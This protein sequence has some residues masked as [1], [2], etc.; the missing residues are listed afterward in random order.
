[1]K[2]GSRTYDNTLAEY[3][4]I[5][6]RAESKEVGRPVVFKMTALEPNKHRF[7]C[8]EV[9]LAMNPDS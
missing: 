3:S 2:K 1:M 4:N 9:R 6:V 7:I 8:M 5:R